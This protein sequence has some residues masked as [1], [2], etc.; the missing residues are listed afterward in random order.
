MFIDCEGFS[1]ECGPCHGE[2]ARELIG[3][4]I[5]MGTLRERI[6]SFHFGN[7]YWTFWRYDWSGIIKFIFDSIFNRFL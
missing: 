7:P 4:A 5:K 3:R 2:E 6:L 1:I